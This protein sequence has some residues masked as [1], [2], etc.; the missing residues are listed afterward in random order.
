C[1]ETGVREAAKAKIRSASAPDAKVAVRLNSV[2]FMKAIKLAEST[3]T[4]HAV[5][6]FWTTG[7]ACTMLE[8]ATGMRLQVSLIILGVS[9]VV[10]P[11]QKSAVSPRAAAPNPGKFTDV[12]SELGV[13]FKNESPHTS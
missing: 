11:A 4:G 7:P 13:H 8:S 10:F 9:V 6:Q 5:P 1:A 2:I 3:T 12:T